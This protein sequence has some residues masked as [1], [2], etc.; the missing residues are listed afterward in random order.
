VAAYILQ[1]VLGIGFAQPFSGFV[2]SNERGMPV[3]AF[4]FNNYSGPNVE[5]TICCD[6]PLGVRATRFIARMAFVELG[7][8]RITVHTRVSNA[9]TIKAIQALGFICEGVRRDYFADED[10]MA[11]AL[12]KSEQRLIRIDP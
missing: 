8:R 10:A 11:Y 1:S 2:I 3:G 4:L 7:A 9:R 12:L 5:L 6:V